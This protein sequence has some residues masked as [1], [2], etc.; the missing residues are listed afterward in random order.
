MIG[1]YKF[2]NKLTGKSYIGQSRNIH[3]RY[4]QHKN[5]YK[6]GRIENSYFHSMLRRFGFDGF[7]FEVLEECPVDE[8]NQ[9]EIFYISKYNTQYPNGYNITAGGESPHYHKLNQK[10]VDEIIVELKENR[11]TQAEI[12]NKYSV[13]FNTICQINVGNTWRKESELYPI[14]KNAIEQ[15]KQKI[16]KIQDLDHKYFTATRRITI[17]KNCGK[18]I[19]DN[20]KTTLCFDCYNKKKTEY[21]PNKEELFNLL[22]HNSFVGVAKMYN[23]SDNAVRKWCDKYNIP[24]HSSYYRSVA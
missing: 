21:I 1:I 8:L 13:H 15:R 2:T 5:R 9:K 10:T 7:E 24:R 18:I 3:K 11:L 12:A 22:S 16:V 6:D 19:T 20:C 14:R 23:V 4:I 17:C